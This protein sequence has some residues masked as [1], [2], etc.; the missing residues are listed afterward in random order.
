MSKRII[1][2]LL[3]FAAFLGLLFLGGDW[4]EINLGIEL[5]ALQNH[6]QP[7]LFMQTIRY[8]F[9]AH[10]ILIANG[11]IFAAVLLALILLFEAIRRRL[12]PW[13]SLTFLA[14][15]LAVVVGFIMKLG[16]PPA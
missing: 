4:D 7:H 13:A 3:Q 14:F 9:G 10:H 8:P 15:V 12:R 1:L 6:T 2:T 5:R 11:L 16:L